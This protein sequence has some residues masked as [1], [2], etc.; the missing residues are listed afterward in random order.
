MSSVKPPVKTQKTLATSLQT[1]SIKIQAS[2]VLLLLNGL[3]HSAAVISILLT[4]FSF[5]LQAVLIVVLGI[6]FAMV[7]HRWRC[8]SEYQLKYYQG[9]WC[10]FAPVVPSQHLTVSRCYYW[11]RYMVIL[12]V[13]NV[14]GRMACFPLMY[15]CCNADDFHLIRIMTKSTLSPFH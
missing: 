13:S 14:S 9:S 4:S 11:S 1:S 5:W 3:L 10:L 12:Q 15:D 2:R 8:F 6:H 7:C